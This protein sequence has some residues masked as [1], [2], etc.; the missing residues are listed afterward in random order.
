MKCQNCGQDAFNDTQLTDSQIKWLL[1]LGLCKNCNPFGFIG[2]TPAKMRELEIPLDMARRFP[3]GI[4]YE[5][6]KWK[7][8]PT[9]G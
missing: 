7:P 2:V 8:I 9:S 3:S 6:G 1:A 4:R 5:N